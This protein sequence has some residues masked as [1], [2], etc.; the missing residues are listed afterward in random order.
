MVF[1]AKTIIIMYMPKIGHAIVQ[2]LYGIYV[3]KE[4]LLDRLRVFRIFFVALFVDDCF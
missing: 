2:I 1:F 4:V 3:D